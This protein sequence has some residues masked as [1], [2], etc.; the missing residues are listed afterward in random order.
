MSGTGP[1]TRDIEQK[2]WSSCCGTGLRTLLKWLGS[3]AQRSG[4]KGPALLQLRL[5][6]SPRL[7]TS[8]CVRRSH[9]KT[10]NPYCHGVYVL[11]ISEEVLDPCSGGEMASS[12]LPLGKKQINEQE[13]GAVRQC[14][15]A[16]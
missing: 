11:M 16:G 4:L 10:R 15:A 3:P 8:I 14:W 7:E 2:S 13:L 5:R 6:F 1:E 9:Q 12:F